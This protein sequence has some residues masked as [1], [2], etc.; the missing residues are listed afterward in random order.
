MTHKMSLRLSKE[1]NLNN[2]TKPR[3]NGKRKTWDGIDGNFKFWQTNNKVVI[4]LPNTGT[5]KNNNT[6]SLLIFT[7][8]IKIF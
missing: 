4:I 2:N 6:R 3:K 1:L 7:M 8:C 5:I